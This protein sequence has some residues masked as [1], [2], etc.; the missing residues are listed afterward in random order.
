MRCLLGLSVESDRF[1]E[2]LLLAIRSGKRRIQ[3]KVIRI[4][5]ERPL[6]FDKCIIDA[7][8]SQVGGGGDVTGD[9]RYRIQ[10]LSFQDKL[11][12]VL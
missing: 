1:R 6:T 12:T 5:L 8:V 3:I 10:F 9:G 4:K 11:K 2:I 7:V